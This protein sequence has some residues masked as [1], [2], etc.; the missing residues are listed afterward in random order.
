M[1]MASHEEIRATVRSMGNPQIAVGKIDIPSTHPPGARYIL[2]PQLDEKHFTGF[3]LDTQTNKIFMFD[4]NSS[5][6]EP[7][8]TI[9]QVPLPAREKRI[10]D[11]KKSQTKATFYDISRSIQTDSRQCGFFQSWFVQQVAAVDGNPEKLKEAIQNSSKGKA[12]AEVGLLR[13]QGRVQFFAEK[14]LSDF[15]F[16]T[17][18][19]RPPLLPLTEKELRDKGLL[20]GG[21]TQAEVSKFT[22]EDW[23]ASMAGEHLFT[24][25]EWKNYRDSLL[26]QEGRI[27]INANERVDF[28]RHVFEIRGLRLSPI[29]VPLLADIAPP[30]SLGYRLRNNKLRSEDWQRIRNHPNFTIDPIDLSTGTYLSAGEDPVRVD[31]PQRDLYLKILKGDPL[32]AADKE[33]VDFLLKDSAIFRKLEKKGLIVSGQQNSKIL[34]SFLGVEG[35]SSPDVLAPSVPEKGSKILSSTPSTAHGAAIAPVGG[36]GGV[37]AEKARESLLPPVLNPDRLSRAHQLPPLVPREQVQ[38]SETRVGIRLPLASEGETCISDLNKG[39]DDFD[40]ISQQ[41]NTEQEH[42]KKQH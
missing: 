13:E 23:K 4:S 36:Q 35:I 40:K 41:I 24:L 37:S 17:R 14:R 1:Q 38:I 25:E 19:R 31:H 20:P 3:V 11:L 9:P 28:E 12:M 33:N 42:F 5:S 7:V 26:I 32:Q 18:D 16:Y 34:I 22:V 6:M 10:A 29:V 21:K 15:L 2:E 39:L 8:R 27:G 30:N